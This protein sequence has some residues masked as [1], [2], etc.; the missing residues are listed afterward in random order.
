MTTDAGSPDLSPQA[1]HAAAL[2]QRSQFANIF[3]GPNGIRAGWRLL[4][5]VVIFI[6]LARLTGF[7]IH[8]IPA[9]H[10]WEQA[11][12]KGT[13]TATQG[14]FEEGIAVLMLILS[15][16]IMSKIE[17]K[18]YADY[19]LPLAEAFGKRF[20]Q[21]IPLGLGMLSILMGL[22]AALHG[23]SIQ[24]MALGGTDALK[25]GVL[26]GVV[27]IL[28]GIFEEFSFRGYMQATLTSGIGFWPAAIVLS[29]LF[30]AGHLSNQGE[31]IYGALMAG[32][33]GLVAAFSLRRTG[34][35]WL[36]IGMH[37]S[38][39][40][41]ETYLYSVPDSGM[42]APGHLLNSSFHG[43]TWITG[44]TVGPEGSAFAFVALLLWAVA[45][46]FLFPAKQTVA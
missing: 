10:A 31:M 12:P 20:W 9:V 1:D 32:S 28:V 23:F 14:I 43:P 26:F 5:F 17:Q 40:W 44:G 25:Y 15:T 3:M 8:H 11:Q 4:I 22:I 7:A 41:G 6:G 18:T 30:G 46:H 13:M 16:L 42:V 34:T 38:W 33:F 24:G 2:P 45:I 39:D 19:N 35:I 21:G 27:F 36:A 37:A 29:I